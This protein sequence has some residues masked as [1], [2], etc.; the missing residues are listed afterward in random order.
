[1]RYARHFLVALNTILPCACICVWSDFG[2]YWECD[3]RSWK[4][5]DPRKHL[6]S[7][8]TGWKGRVLSRLLQNY[9]I[10]VLE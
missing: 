9:D 2:S 6:V 7:M 10:L 1:M 5:H 4:V 8:N 3:V